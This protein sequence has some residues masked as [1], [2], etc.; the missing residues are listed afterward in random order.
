VVTAVVAA[1]LAVRTGATLVTADTELAKL[2]IQ[3]EVMTLPRNTV[4]S[5]YRAAPPAKS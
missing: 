4:S 5:R 2:G 3:L 1:E